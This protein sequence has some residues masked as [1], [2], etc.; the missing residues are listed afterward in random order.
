MTRIPLLIT[1]AAAAALAGCNKSDHTIVAGGEPDDNTGNAVANANVQL[2][3][4]IVASKSYRCADNR[5]VYVD[6]MSD[7]SAR[8]KNKREEVGT[9]VAAG[10]PDLK[11]D[12]KTPSITYKG[13][14][15]KA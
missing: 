6:W 8:V 2:P 9:V 11:G 5:L 4:S 12:P 7:G 3:P 1:L 13:Q 15:C 10:A 14:S